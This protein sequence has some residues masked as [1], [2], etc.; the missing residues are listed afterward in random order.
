MGVGLKSIIHTHTNQYRLGFEYKPYLAQKTDYAMFLGTL[1]GCQKS[2][3]T[4]KIG[5]KTS[6]F[7]VKEMDENGAWTSDLGPNK[8]QYTSETTLQKKN[9]III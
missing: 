6:N 2:V 9:T 7:I 1:W 3:S 8:S 4:K 5:A